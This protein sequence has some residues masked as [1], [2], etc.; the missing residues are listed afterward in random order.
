M[1]KIMDKT[2]LVEKMKVLL[3]STF[4]L[5]LKAH[6]YHWN[7]TGPDFGQYHEFFGDLYEELHGSIDT[8]AEEIRKL[9]AFAPGALTRYS[10]MSV[11]EDEL[12]IPE[13]AIMFA[14][15]ANDN[16]KVINL[17]YEARAIADEINAFGTVNYLE[18]RISTHEK[19]AWM[20]KSF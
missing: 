2:Q 17:L 1:E 12:M 9:G 10:E 4:S 8:T 18:D 13:S 14:R 7:V 20:L 19:H 15:L 16:D 6:N 3:A 5:Y 11:I